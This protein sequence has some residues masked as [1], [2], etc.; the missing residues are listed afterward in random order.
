MRSPFFVSLVV[1]LAACGDSGDADAGDD[2][3]AGVAPATFPE[4]PTSADAPGGEEQTFV[5]LDPFLDQL[6]DDEWS[7]I[8]YDLDG[9][10]SVWPDEDVPCLP[11]SPMRLVVEDGMGCRDNVSGRTLFNTFGQL[12]GS[13]YGEVMVDTLR[14]GLGAP[15]LFVNGWSGERDDPMVEAGLAFA[16]HGTSAAG[17]S[18]TNVEIAMGL[19]VVDG[20]PVAAPDLDGGDDFFA[21]ADSWNS[22]ADRPLAWDDAAY[23]SGG[24]LVIRL[25]DRIPMTFGDEELTT[26]LLLTDARLVVDVSSGAPGTAVLTGRWPA[27]DL[28]ERGLHSGANVCPGTTGYGFFEALVE[29]APD[30]RAAPGTGGSTEIVCDAVSVAIP[31]TRTVPANVA[32]VATL[33]RPSPCGG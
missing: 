16:T 1:V 2:A 3:D 26:T 5:L 8:G 20:A 28:L 10:C 4:R 22:A 11:P 14:A 12:A 13:T 24:E 23:V 32:G 29:I 25:P 18:A 17:T 21:D 19:P 30:T 33:N 31:F 27:M 9:Y 6:V 7:T 15:I